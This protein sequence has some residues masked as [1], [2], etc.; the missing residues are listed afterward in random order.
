MKTWYNVMK[1]ELLRMGRN[2][3]FIIFS[4]LMPLVFYAIYT[5]TVDDTVMI[6]GTEWKA[7][8][9]V[10]MT[11]FS[12]MSASVTTMGIQLLHDRRQPW[13]SWVK[14]LPM[15]HWQYFLGRLSA[16]MVLN[17]A[18]ILFMFIIVANWKDIDLGFY[19][20]VKIVA[21]V[22]LAILPFLALG[23]WVSVFKTAETAAGFANL[24][25]LGLAII[26]GL[27]MPLRQLP[28]FVREVGA[29]TPGHLYADGAWSILA[30]E[31]ISALTIIV[32]A[33]YFLFFLTGSLWTYRR[34]QE[35]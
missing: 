4:M 10:S 17:L 29:W 27:W 1:I 23:T 12:M 32:L 6:D 33:G 7:Y 21:W 9:L 18:V 15:K 22:W 13:M 25:T 24:I 28:V 3:Y 35:G 16:L 31:S 11:C 2:P 30:G 20:W 5:Q 14:S 8:F 34:F 19:T 26:G